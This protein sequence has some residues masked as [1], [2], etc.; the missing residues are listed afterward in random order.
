[1]RTTR[2]LHLAGAWVLA[3]SLP[4]VSSPQIADLTALP[5][6]AWPTNGGDLY[7]RRYSSLSQI[8]RGNVASLKAVWRARLN[9]SGVGPQYSGEAE[10]IVVDGVLYIV[11][12]A[13]D[14]F[15]IDVE[16]GET[17]W[18]YEAHLDG[19]IDTICC[20]W[21]NRGLGFGDGKVFVGQLDSKLVALDRATGA[22]VWSVQAERWQ[23]GYSITS[24]TARL[25]GPGS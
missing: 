8:N 6:A 3:M 21:T 7:N 22:I 2:G 15:A 17:L 19:L 10:P 13:D 14:V 4:V 11:T 20:G 25:P 5:A 9:G 1:M 24:C 12:G 23:E 16:T 18:E